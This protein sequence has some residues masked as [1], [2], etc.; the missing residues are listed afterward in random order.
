MKKCTYKIKQTDGSV[1]EFD[2]LVELDYA[3][4]QKDAIRNLKSDGVFYFSSKE[5]LDRK[6]L[7]ERKLDDL[8]KYM[9][10]KSKT[11]ET[12]M[13]DEG[14][15]ET[16]F[17]I[18][19]SEGTS[20]FIS[21]SGKRGSSIDSDG[22][23][24][25][26]FEAFVTPFNEKDYFTSKSYDK[27]LYKDSTVAKQMKQ[28]WGNQTDAGT[29][30]HAVFESIVN[31]DKS[32]N[33]TDDQYKLFGETVDKGKEK[34]EGLIL[35]F[36]KILESIK[37]KH[38]ECS[39][40]TEVPI[41]S[42]QLASCFEKT[43]NS[44]GELL[45][46]VNGRIDLLVIDKNGVA[47]IYDYKVSHKEVGDWRIKDNEVIA[48]DSTWSSTKK[49][50]I[51]Y[52]MEM[53]RAMLEQWGVKVGSVNIVPI[54][55]GIEYE[56]TL[57]DGKNIG[58]KYINSVGS[59]NIISDSIKGGM[60]RRTD[61]VRGVFPVER[62][63]DG[64]DGIKSIEEPMRQMFPTLTLSST[65]ARK[66]ST[67]AWF[68]DHKV[69]ES[70][71]GS[72]L[73]ENGKYWFFN[74][75]SGEDSRI[76]ANSETELIQKL[77]EYV[78]RLNAKGPDEIFSIANQIES[79]LSGSQSFDSFSFAS[80]NDIALD[81]LRQTFKPYIGDGAE[82]DWNFL[83]NETLI[84][85]GIF[86]FEKNGFV[87]F[88]SI[89]NHNLVEQLKLP[90]GKSV[91]GT[92]KRDISIDEHKV[93]KAS[94]GNI[95]RIKVMTLINSEYGKFKDYK[96]NRICSY[97]PWLSM[98][99]EDSF[100]M[101]YDNFDK[102]CNEHNIE[103]NLKWENFSSLIEYTKSRIERLTGDDK[104]KVVP[105]G[106]IFTPDQTRE[107]LLELASQAER[108]KAN[109]SELRTAIINGEFD[110]KDPNQLSYMYI[111]RAM[112]H[113]QGFQVFI[114]NDPA[115]FIDTRN[116]FA[117]GANLTT[118]QMAP[119]LNIQNIAKI[120]NQAEVHIRRK[121]LTYL[122]SYSKQIKALY[123]EKGR[124]RLIGG[125]IAYFDNL[126]EPQIGNIKTLRL[127]REDD[128]SLSDAER[129]F[130][131]S[132]LTIVNGFRYKNDATKIAEAKINGTYYD[133]PLKKASFHTQR[134][135]KGV[136]NAAKD[137]FIDTF[138]FLKIFSQQKEAFESN[139]ASMT[140]YNQYEI[141][142]IT[143][144][145]ILDNNDIGDFETDLERLLIDVIATYTREEEFNKIIPHV[146]AL[147]MVLQYHSK[148]FGQDIRN[149]N[150]YIEKFM[151][152]NVYSQP[153]MDPN[154]RSVYK[155]ANVAK[156]ITSATVLGFN[157]KSGVRELLQGAWIHLSR[158][159][160]G[161]YGKDQFTTK[162][163]AK[164]WTIICKL[165]INDPNL[166][167]LLDTLNVDYGMANAGMN[168]VA[169]ILNQSKTGIKNFNSDKM[170]IFNRIPDSYHRLG[171]LIA[172]MI[173]DG[174]WESHTADEYGR[175]QYDFTTDKRFD[176]LNDPNAD[177]KS[178]EYKEQHA[179]YLAMRDQFIREGFDIPSEES[180][181]PIPPLPRAYTLQEG[182]SI[183]SFA[184]LC[185][186]HYD[187]NTQMLAKH[188]FLG[189][190][191]LQF[192]TFLSAKLEQWILKPGTYD[193][194]QYENVYDVDGVQLVRVYT[195]DENGIPSV[196]IKRESD[197]TESDNY[198]PYKE[199]KGKYMEGMLY[200]MW[201]F[202]ENLVKWDQEALKEFWKHPTKRANL[203]LMLNDFVFMSLMMWL[204]KSLF[205]SE[206]SPELGALG[207]LGASALYTS[208]SDGPIWS[209]GESMFGD[210]NPPMYSTI[211]SIWSNT[212]SAIT[213][214]KGVFESVVNTFGVLK[215]LKEVEGLFE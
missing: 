123:E 40:F 159:M 209:V 136:I 192:R 60:E 78:D 178:K 49:L 200:T 103:N 116:T 134:Y 23:L 17:S 210:L 31:P 203:Y 79:I 32:L 214:K 50:G 174:C 13:T 102:L 96:I 211:K 10:N 141:N 149:L 101:L 5:N 84:A 59:R 7:T 199:W 114:E 119:S 171:I 93:L 69:F 110:F 130:L 146:Q 118:G 191:A 24:K 131:I 112:L 137:E 193:Q 189:A 33:L 95:D 160:A 179:L 48:K 138:N 105:G 127:K 205:L 18:P 132:F 76:F 183:K 170:Y 46:S 154:L 175:V 71:P 38:P 106:L 140:V 190:F 133:V 185:F 25:T 4:S 56:K 169:E 109:S 139:K 15:T 145:E 180:G 8:F 30:I 36:E 196:E 151:N 168:E 182:Q 108:L 26:T 47:H 165:S 51:E 161:M 80:R 14:S 27:S 104:M 207:H 65:L 3:L 52:Q 128:A 181:Q 1:V 177:K 58:F 158:T 67:V 195:F 111:M 197:V 148:M 212:C 44:K 64:I 194:G 53:Y 9:Q 34:I 150:E 164:A 6:G 12:F 213:G 142:S 97:N 208:F 204:V 215:P 187:K 122:P 54:K 188:M 89:T 162:D 184:D 121:Q 82:S 90:K 202:G 86:A 73:A 113:L 74:E 55:I 42:K 45:T 20:R 87:E 147:K 92:T 70:K 167:T 11:L 88:I 157:L 107:G 99:N 172:K 176:L 22:N 124:N 125:E 21:T 206:D 144:Q 83:R 198:E 41:I 62:V 77:T 81:M 19:G 29:I 156:N 163:I 35:D 94:Y 68:R 115:T 66:E 120:E 153:I 72:K 16:F 173:H 63:T 61:S 117:V 143:R 39:V 37:E 43:T 135:N 126:F 152:L 186:G 28:D 57:D 2:S 98:T 155:I 75:L 100:E 91:L 166:I 85:A 129:N 201:S